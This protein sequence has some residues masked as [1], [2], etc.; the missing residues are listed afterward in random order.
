[1][2]AGLPAG[3]F[4][5]VSPGTRQVTIGGAIAADVHG[6]NHHVAGQLRHPRAVVRPA[7]AQRRAAD[8]HPAGRSGPV[9]GHGG[10]H[11]PDRA[12]RVGHRPAQAGRHRRGSGST[13]C[14][15][16]DID[17]TMAVLAEHDRTPSATPWPGPTAWP[18]A[19]ALGRSVV[20]S[21][22]FADLADLPARDRAD[23]FL[24]APAPRLGVPGLFP[25][26]ADQPLHGR[27][28]QRGVVPQG[29]PPPRGRAADHREFF[30]PLD[31]IRNWNR[32]YGPAGFRQY[33]YVVPFGQEAAV[34][35]SFEL[36]SAGTRAVVRDGAQAVRRG[37][38]RPALVPDAGLDAGPGLPG[39]HAAPGRTCWPCSTA[40]RRGGRPRLPGQGLAGA[41]RVLEQMYPRLAEFRSCGPS[42]TP[43]VS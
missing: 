21:G 8:G 32:V 40:G 6:K 38:P 42:W 28:G 20:T 15:P 41:R 5:P 29:A 35:R 43:K 3:W 26:G 34:R 31:G 30:H 18:A 19:P 24:F 1:M 39:P 7:A 36:I 13:P 22:D 17:E 14:A 9:L 2:V 23:P 33:Q 16:R 27:P 4:V 12:H 11:G 10:R 37:R 25:P